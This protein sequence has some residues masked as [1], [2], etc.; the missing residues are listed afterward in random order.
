MAKF[1][2][3]NKPAVRAAV[4]PGTASDKVGLGAPASLPA[5]RM[6]DGTADFAGRDAGAWSAW[7][8]D[9]FPAGLYRELYRELCR[10][11]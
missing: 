9:I 5:P 7:S 6:R 2:A 4:G 8:L 10:D 1:L 3:G 11:L